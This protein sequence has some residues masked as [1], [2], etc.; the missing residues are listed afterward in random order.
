VTLRPAAAA[1]SDRKP[2]ARAIISA[3]A[4]KTTL[5]PMIAGRR[6]KRSVSR[7]PAAEPAMAPTM[8]ADTTCST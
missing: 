1:T 2:G 8:V 6:P 4:A 7:P 5:P 3:P